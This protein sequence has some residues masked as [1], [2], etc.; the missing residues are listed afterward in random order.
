MRKPV[1][2][3]A[4]NNGADRTIS[5]FVIR[6][7]DS[8]L[9]LVSVIVSKI[10]SF[11]L[12]SVAESYLVRNPEDRFSYDEAHLCVYLAR[13]FLFLLVSRFWLR[14]VIMALAGLLFF[15]FFLFFFFNFVFVYSN[16]K[17]IYIPR[18]E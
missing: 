14:L 3:Y 17:Y 7:L 1:L 6:C 4:N 8:M 5:V 16:R 18:T 12:V 10:L 2:P 11:Q 9:P 15:S 13:A